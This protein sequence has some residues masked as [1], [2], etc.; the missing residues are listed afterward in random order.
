[1]HLPDWLQRLGARVFPGIFL[2]PDEPI[3]ERAW[4]EILTRPVPTVIHNHVTIN[5]GGK[6][7][8]AQA[9]REMLT[10]VLDDSMRDEPE[11]A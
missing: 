11:A 10:K 6:P 9:F 5:Y 8:D 1:M 7:E 4:A 2:V 3:S